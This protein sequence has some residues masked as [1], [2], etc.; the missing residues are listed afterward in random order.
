LVVPVE[1]P[2]VKGGREVFASVATYL[3]QVVV[4]PG[5]AGGLPFPTTGA[6]RPTL[7]PRRRQD[8]ESVSTLKVLSLSAARPSTA[9][10]PV[11]TWVC[12]HVAM[13]SATGLIREYS[14]SISFSC[15]ARGLTLP[16]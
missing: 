13:S 5:D 10:C 2:P 16:S 12:W 8:V 15:G 1:V 9:A 7:C 11:G 3:S 14:S 6:L 4:Q